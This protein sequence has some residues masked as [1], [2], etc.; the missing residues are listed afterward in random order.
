MHASRAQRALATQ[1]C[2]MPD[3][4]TRRT[5]S[6]GRQGDT[7]F[8]MNHKG[9]TPFNPNGQTKGMGLSQH[10]CSRKIRW[11]VKHGWTCVQ[12]ICTLNSGAI[13]VIDTHT[14][15]ME[16]M[17]LL[18]AWCWHEVAHIAFMQSMITVTWLSSYKP[19]HGK[20]KQLSCMT[21]WHAGWWGLMQYALLHTVYKRR[22]KNA[23]SKTR[24]ALY[25]QHHN[26]HLQL[27]TAALE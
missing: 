8:I 7:R 18:P 2:T 1:S 24:L 6:R 15:G 22:C 25:N 11:N 27:V 4:K 19:M 20:G 3:D 12:K 17:P 13:V 21:G 9:D 23:Y 10:R 16:F 14:H 5:P 26:G